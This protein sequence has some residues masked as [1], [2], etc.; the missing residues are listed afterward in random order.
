MDGV[1]RLERDD[2]VAGVEVLP[3]V[4]LPE[5]EDPGEGRADLLAVDAGPDLPHPRLGLLV[6]G[7]RPVE[8]GLGEDPLAHEPADA[9][10]VEPRE[11]PLRLRRGQLG[12][13]LAR[14]EADEH[15]SLADRAA[16]LEADRRHDP[17]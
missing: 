17:G 15:L 2:R 5:A 8:L 6:L 16:G 14:V 10:E 9:V 13:L 7:A 12:P 11:V 4:H 1:E 3:K